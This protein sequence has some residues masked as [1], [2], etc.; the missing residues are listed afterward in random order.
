MKKET[1]FWIRCLDLMTI[2][3]FGLV[4]VLRGFDIDSIVLGID[5]A[6][7]AGG[8]F[9][10][11]L[12]VCVGV[13]LICHEITPTTLLT[14]TIRWGLHTHIQRFFLRPFVVK[15]RMAHSTGTS[16]PYTDTNKT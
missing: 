1:P 9:L 4:A 12:L 7:V 15:T 2:L 5:F 16:V 6:N 11:S 8:V 13:G 14:R 10:I 3:S